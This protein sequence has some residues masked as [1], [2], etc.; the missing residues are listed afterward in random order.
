[1][2]SK[3]ARKA[4]SRDS[5]SCPIEPGDIE[6]DSPVAPLA[7]SPGMPHSGPEMR[8][9]STNSTTVSG[10][11]F[12]S[13][14][15]TIFSLRADGRSASSRFTLTSTKNSAASASSVTSAINGP[16]SC[17]NC[18][19]RMKKQRKITTNTSRRA[20]ISRTFSAISSSRKVTPASWPTSV[21]CCR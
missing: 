13:A 9:N 7:A 16:W 10:A 5:I 18:V 21:P 11:A 15:P 3:R 19:S 20:R 1:V 4:I 2:P 12:S 17:M 14:Q 8:G 6:F